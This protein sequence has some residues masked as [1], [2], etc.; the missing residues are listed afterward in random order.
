MQVNGAAMTTVDEVELGCINGT[1]QV[2]RAGGPISAAFGYAG[3]GG[4]F[5]FA[6]LVPGFQNP[7]VEGDGSNGNLSDAVGSVDQKNSSARN[8]G[9]T[10]AVLPARPH[11]VS[12]DREV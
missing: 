6:V 11:A 8:A 7:G 3:V 5:V 10:D 4:R 9:G 12:A 1:G 2:N